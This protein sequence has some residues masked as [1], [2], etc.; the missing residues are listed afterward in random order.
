MHFQ[1]KKEIDAAMDTDTSTYASTNTILY[2]VKETAITIQ[3]EFLNQTDEEFLRHIRALSNA[4]VSKK[5]CLEI[6]ENLIAFLTLYKHP[7]ASDVREVR[8]AIFHNN[9][10]S[11]FHWLQVALA[12]WLLHPW[13]EM[14]P[15]IMWEAEESYEEMLEVYSKQVVEQSAA[16]ESAESAASASPVQ[17]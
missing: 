14:L 7:N 16:K 10:P 6:L 3:H 12:Y 13:E 1:E 2:G 8:R 15:Y 17:T 5:E 4:P 9:L 11:A